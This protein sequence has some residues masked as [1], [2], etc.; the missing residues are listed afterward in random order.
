MLWLTLAPLARRKN[1]GGRPPA[2][3]S[4]TYGV[5][6]LQLATAGA[7]ALRVGGVVF[8]HGEGGGRLG[9]RWRR[10][11]EGRGWH[12]RWR[13]ALAADIHRLG[14]LLQSAEEQQKQNREREMQIRAPSI[15]P[16]LFLF[17]ATPLSGNSG[18]TF[19]GSKEEQSKT[20]CI[21]GGRGRGQ[22]HR[23]VIMQGSFC[24][25]KEVR[26][27]ESIILC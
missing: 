11:V 21:G 19:S 2:A 6:S 8:L 5:A 10:L 15:T 1:R 26:Q 16:S 24:S 7:A 3:V 12:Q 25:D 4:I 23:T 14:L 27:G 13:E 20:I 18:V 22:C 9:N 17:V